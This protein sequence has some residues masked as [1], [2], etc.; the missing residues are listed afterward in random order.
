MKRQPISEWQAE[1]GPNAPCKETLRRW[2]KQHKVPSVRVG[3]RWYRVIGSP[4]EY[5]PDDE[6]AKT[7]DYIANAIR[8]AQP[9]GRIYLAGASGHLKIGWTRK[10]PEKRISELQIASPVPIRLVIHV[11]GDH[12]YERM[13]HAVFQHLRVNREWFQRH[14]DIAWTFKRIRDVCE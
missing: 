4:E 13:L 7:A 5:T 11:P 3:G 2:C 8:K 6:I 9:T 12:R 14:A 10:D 1:L